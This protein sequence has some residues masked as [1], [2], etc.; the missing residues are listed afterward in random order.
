MPFIDRMRRRFRPRQRFRPALRAR[1]LGLSLLASL[2]VV[3]PGCS[4]D[5]DSSPLPP[6]ADWTVFVY[7]HGDHNL[8]PSLV[9]DIAKM[10][11]AQLNAKVK[12]IVLADFD[13]SRYVDEEETEKYPT[14]AHWL[15]I[16]GSGADPEE[17]LTEPEKNLDDPQVLSAA[18]AKAFKDYPASRYGLVLWN[19]GGAWFGGFGGDSQ[20]GAQRGSGLSLEQLAGAIR[21]GLD[22]AGLSGSRAL[23]FLAFDT[24]LLGGAEPAY[25]F[26]DLSKVYIANA[27]IDY[28]SGWN[29]TDTLSLIARNPQISALEFG[30]QEAEFWNALHNTQDTDDRLLRSHIVIDTARLD[31]LAQA[32]VTLTQ[33]LTDNPGA[34][35]QVAASAYFSLPSYALTVD[36]TIEWDG[37]RDYAEFLSDL[38]SQP[39][40]GAIASAA[41]NVQTELEAL[42]I[43]R[44]QGE[45]RENQ[46][47]FH[48]ALPSINVLNNNWFTEYQDKAAAWNQASQWSQLLNILAANRDA[49]PPT[50][51]AEL[52]NG[53]QPSAARPPTLR[54]SAAEQDIGNAIMNVYRIDPNRPDRAVAYGLAAAGALNPGQATDLVWNGQWVMIG[55]PLQPA[56]IIPWILRGRDANA[57]L[58]P[59]LLAAVGTLVTDEG[60]IDAYLLFQDGATAA[61]T[62]VVTDE[63]QTIS[64]SVDEV[65]LAYPDAQFVPT[66]DELDLADLQRRSSAGTPI[67]LK[68]IVA[69]RRIQQDGE[70]PASIPVH[71]AAAAPGQ[72]VLRVE[73]EDVWGNDAS[74]QR[75]VTVVDPF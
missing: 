69:L 3:L 42:T 64:L 17:L 58:R 46:G 60:A 35:R 19:H 6:R 44:V 1:I 33:A 40:L 24:C 68:P 55:E 12:V 75:T 28:G 29:Y 54:L 71:H 37:L 36:K 56:K 48:I 27:E 13:A 30:R 63:N 70:T 52:L 65:L 8:S 15:S 38:A 23:E 7:G 61:E 50:L 73:V 4:G 47:A 14:G 51:Q 43:N 67:S 39:T 57:T 53:D 9:N 72:Y 34:A 66:V 5:D 41:Q 21:A 25:A 18:I 2:G 11:E 32:T 26:K 62:L 45:L 22:D 10:S 31:E 16:R 20:D 49:T 74:L 59:P